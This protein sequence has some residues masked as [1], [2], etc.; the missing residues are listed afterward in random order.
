MHPRLDR[1]ACPAPAAFAAANSLA[2][3]GHLWTPGQIAYSAD[4]FLANEFQ[5]KQPAD[6]NRERDPKMC[7]GQD[8]HHPLAGRVGLVNRSHIAP[9]CANG[10][11]TG[12][13]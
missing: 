11:I 9:T 1:K 5:K 8:A 2:A 6:Q 10:K 12:D 7:V 3:M 4:P 13:G